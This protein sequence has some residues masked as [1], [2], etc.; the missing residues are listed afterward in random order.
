MTLKCR[1]LL[2]YQTS[3]K[4]RFLKFRMNL[5]Y[6]KSHL[7]LK[8]RKNQLP[9]KY[10]MSLMFHQHLRCPMNLKYHLPR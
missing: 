2:M 10:Q 7:Y 6:L 8:Y 1:Q 3:L 5:K 9:R 4:C